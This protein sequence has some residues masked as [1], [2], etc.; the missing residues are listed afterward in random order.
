VYI[1]LIFLIHSSIVGHLGYFQSLAIVNSD[2]NFFSHSVSCLL[3]L[4]TVSFAVQ[5]PFSLMQS[6]L[7]ILS[8]RC[9]VF[10]GALFR[11]AFPLPICSSVFPTA[12]WSCFKVSGLIL[13][14]LIYFEL[15]LV[16]VKDSVLVTVFYMWI[17]SFQNSICRKG[18]L[19]PT[20]CF[21]LLCGRSVGCR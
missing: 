19:F 4:V 13:R 21:Q 14:S 15:I 8:L 3:S 16:Q 10:W 11:K 5:K 1:H 9:W 2:A 6:Y 20:V 12:S 17:S 18:Y 7:F